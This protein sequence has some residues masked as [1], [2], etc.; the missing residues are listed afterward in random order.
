VFAIMLRNDTV[1]PM[2]AESTPKSKV[3]SFPS[4]HCSQNSDLGL[5]EDVLISQDVHILQGCISPGFV[6][7]RSEIVNI[8]IDERNQTLQQKRNI[9][10]KNIATSMIKT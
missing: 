9:I 3:F 2:T 5:E 1:K 8:I 10:F 4:V 6:L 7:P